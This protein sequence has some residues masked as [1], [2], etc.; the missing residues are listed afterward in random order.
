[1]L[2]ITRMPIKDTTD[3][4]ES[5]HLTFRACEI[6]REI[7]M[8][9]ASD[10]KMPLTKLFGISATGFNSGEDDIE[11]YN[12]M[13]ESE[14]RSKCKYDLLTI[15]EICCSIYLALYLMTLR[16]NLNHCVYFQHNNRKK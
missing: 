3:I 11:N 15:L 6:L 13:I 9:I 1:M 5:K 12:A 10:L 7:R 4:L 8:Q 2:R 14:I 16:L